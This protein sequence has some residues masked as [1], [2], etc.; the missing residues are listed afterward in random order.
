LISKKSFWIQFLFALAWSAV[1]RTN[2]TPHTAA[3]RITAF[4][5]NRQFFHRLHPLHSRIGI[6]E[7]KR[8]VHAYPLLKHSFRLG[9][10]EENVIDTSWFDGTARKLV[11][12]FDFI[13]ATSRSGS[14]MQSMQQAARDDMLPLRLRLHF[15]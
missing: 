6:I 13:V 12:T 9:R 3:G 14:V 2:T 8:I 15:L 7:K 1:A 11:G 10:V 4:T 5:D